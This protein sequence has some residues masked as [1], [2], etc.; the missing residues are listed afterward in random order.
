MHKSVAEQA[1][2]TLGEMPAEE[3]QT[4]GHAMVDWIARYLRESRRYPVLSRVAPGEITAQLPGTAPEDGAS[5]AEIFADFERVL[6]PGM[7]HWNSPGFLAYFCSTGSGPGILGELLTAALNQQAM[8]WRTSPAATEVETLVLEWVRQL[9]HLPPDFRGVLT[10]GGSMSN[11]LALHA[12]RESAIPEVRTRG[13]AQ[14]PDGMAARIYCTE[15]AHSSV[16]KAAIVLGVGQESLHR[17]AVDRGFRMQPAALREA[18]RADRRLGMRPMA[19]VACVGTTSTGSIDP[20]AEIAAVCEEERLW[21]HIDAAHAG[22]AAMAPQH[23]WIFDGVG[24]ADSV[25]VNPHKWMFTPLDAGL[26][27]CRRLGMLK[28]SLALTP[29]YLATPEGE[30]NHLMD[31]G[32]QLSRRFRAL[33]LW[34]VLRYFGASGIRA[35]IEEHVRLAQQFASWVEDDAD[36]ELA[37]PPM[38][39]LVCFRAVPAALREDLPKLDALNEELLKRVNASGDVFLSHARVGGRYTIRLAVGHIQTQQADLARAW[40]LLRE[41]LTSLHGCSGCGGSMPGDA[42]RRQD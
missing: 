27:Y 12:A 26:L 33:K 25:T 23:A 22:S 3:F 1:E 36:F 38:L 18:I 16:D 24:R 11:L 30:A 34:M 13:L 41:G 14:R 37:T 20:I 40:Q 10:D 31:T 28:Q 21:L 17:I 4:A 39:S 35:R 19:V 6:M 2:T 8:L 7:T 32:I 5:M 15:Y 9:L 42:M 29:D